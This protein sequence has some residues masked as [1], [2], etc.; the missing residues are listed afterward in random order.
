MACFF[1]VMVSGCIG[2]Q[3]GIART[4]VMTKGEIIYWRGF[5][6]GTAVATGVLTFFFVVVI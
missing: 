4:N 3:N 1:M 2:H 6:M 5:A